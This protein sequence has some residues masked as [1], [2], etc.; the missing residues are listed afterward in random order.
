MRKR[1][2]TFKLLAAIGVLAAAAFGC[3]RDSGSSSP[4]VEDCSDPVEVSMQLQWFDQAEFAGYYAAQDRGFYEEQCLEVTLIEGRGDIVPIELLETGVD[5]VSSLV[6]RALQLREEGSNVVDIAQIFE[7]S[8]LVQVA[9]A[10]SGIKEASDLRGK[11]LGSWGYGNEHELIAG[12]RRAGIDPEE[13]V[14]IV[15]QNDTDMSEF[16]DRSIDAAQAMIYN[17]YAQILEVVNPDT[18]E[19]YQPSDLVVIDWNEVGTGM[20]HDSIW[21]DADRLDEEPGFRDTAVRF[22][23][24]T[25]EGWI[26]CRDNP[27]GCVDIILERSPSQGRSH[28]IWQ[29]NEVNALIWPSREGIG[30]VPGDL[31]EQTVE[32]SVTQEI[33]SEPPQGDAYRND[34]VSE[35]HASLQAKGLDIFGSD[36]KRDVVELKEG[37]E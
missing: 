3:S 6:P 34:I 35:A 31:W 8:G 37:G 30:K 15:Q 9:W 14:T 22:V 21:A 29:L 12:L 23:Q 33:L 5:F 16:L 13:D 4:L 26:W 11:R 27:D 28:Q 2:S 18:G 24:A 36:W 7:R 1:K 20:L 25:L 32:V 17:E 10:D 19:L